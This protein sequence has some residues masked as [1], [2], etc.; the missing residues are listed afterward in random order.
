MKVFSLH[1]GGVVTGSINPGV[2]PCHALFHHHTFRNREGPEYRVQ[3]RVSVSSTVLMDVCPGK[4][5]RIG[6][7]IPFPFLQQELELCWSILLD[8][9]GSDGT[10]AGW[11]T[12]VCLN[13]GGVG[14]VVGHQ[15]IPGF[16]GTI[17]IPQC[18]A[19]LRLREAGG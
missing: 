15:V 18:K 8:R 1:H 17:S 13:F 14:A 4:E 16:N 7:D 5:A 11:D 10:W 6:G 3:F 19:V 9:Y 12:A 2:E